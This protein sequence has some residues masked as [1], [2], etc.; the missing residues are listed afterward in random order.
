M[1]L[2]R[3]IAE[4]TKASGPLWTKET[5]VNGTN[6]VSFFS[7]LQGRKIVDRDGKAVGKLADLSLK[8]GETLLEISRI[9]YTSNILGEKVILPLSSV[10]SINSDI[11]LDVA[12][13]EIP[14]GR[15]SEK[16]LLVTETILDKQIVDIDGLKVV[17][18]ND[19]L[20]AQ[21]K[22]SLCLVAVDVGFNGILRRLGLYG[23]SRGLLDRL[24]SNIIP[25]SYIDPLDP[26]LRSIHLKISRK[27]IKDLHP[28]DIADILE[29]LNNKDRLFILDSL[30]DETAAETME[31]MDPQVQATMVKQM[32][33]DDVADILENMNPDDAADL[34]G[35]LPEEK[36]SE[37]L[38][39]MG[40]EEAEEVK[41]LMRYSDRTAGSL[42]TTEY[43]AVPSECRVQDVFARLRKS[44]QEIDMIYYIYVQD[45]QE[46][47]LGVMSLRD[48]LLAD[49]AEKACSVMKS[50]VISVLP[51]SS[52]EE[53]TNL[54][55]KYDFLSVP[56]VDQNSKILG[57]VT[58]DDALDDIIPEDLKKH[59]PWNYHKLRR[60]RGV[61]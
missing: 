5:A 38:N 6:R 55:S 9:V 22:R 44:G 57:I 36:A 32:K 61:A 12:R 15:L 48:L 25:W 51:T 29:D 14:P 23:L 56:V 54:L 27:T 35:I 33:S 42:M 60:V 3:N 47:L 11:R 59:L 53:V 45:D 28:A 39:L 34:L 18:V 20:V 7:M 2:S 30:G 58:F 31:E 49:P 16:E 46:H 52:V 4:K 50:D 21:V 43:I 26:S 37:V 8:P 41:W 13:D 10:S 17:R 19:V 1:R 24:P 40:E